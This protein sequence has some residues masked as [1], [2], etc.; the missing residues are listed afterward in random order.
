MKKAAIAI[1]LSFIMTLTACSGKG[2]ADAEIQLPIYGAQEIQYEIAEAKYMDI[3]ETKSMGVTIG[4]PYAVYLTYPADALVMS[5]NALKGRTVTEG[6]IL[7]EL[8]SSELDYE[9]SNQQ[10]IVNAAYQSSL[11]GDRAAAL[12]YEIEKLKLDMMLEDKAEYTIKAPFDGIIT[13]TAAVTEGSV[14]TAGALCCAVSEVEKTEVYL[15]GGEA[16]QFRFGQKVQV[17]IDNTMYDAVVTEAPDIAPATATGSSA[18]RVIFDLGDETMAQVL[19]ESAMAV[20][21]GWATVY[22]TTERKNVLAVPNSAVKTSGTESYVTLVD[23]EERYKLK[24]TIG[25]SLGGY[26]EIIDGISEG[27]VVISEGSGIFTEAVSNTD[28]QNAAQGEGQRG[29]PGDGGPPSERSGERG[30]K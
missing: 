27:D 11:S 23:G 13:Q 29:N 2:N 30:N 3:S 10:T 21:S 24:V 6:E 16:S 1:L 8:D 7:A 4:Y 22:V 14:V 12:Q 20:S 9:I 26:T 19:E 5:F 18:N 25:T 15:D 28:N 17:K